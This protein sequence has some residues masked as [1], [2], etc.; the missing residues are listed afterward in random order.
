MCL[1]FDAEEWKA[2]VPGIIEWFE[3][4]GDDLPSQLWDELDGLKERLGLH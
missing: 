1:R 3:K 2:E 4:F